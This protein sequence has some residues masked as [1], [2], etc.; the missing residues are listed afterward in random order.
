MDRRSA[1]IA[2]AGSVPL[3]RASDSARSTVLVELFTSEGCSSCPPADGVLAHLDHQPVSGVDIVVM[4]EHVDYWNHLG[5]VDAYSSPLYS[6]R[7]QRY[8]TRFKLESVYTPQMVIDG[9]TQVLGSDSYKITS[10][11]EQAALTPRA[12]VHIER[13]ETPSEEQADAARVYLSVQSVPASLR[14]ETFDVLLA[15]TE[16]GL[17]SYVTR[18]E[19]L[20]RTLKHTGVVRNLLSVTELNP[21]KSRGYTATLSI[22]IAKTWT[23]SKMRAVLF[24]Q[25]R[26]TQ[27]IAGVG[28][29]VL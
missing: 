10:A 28:S 24:L 12:A 16:S 15:L 23:R 19:N 29:C 17:A 4:A 11:I 18:G 22:G 6:A 9:R 3:L 13:S 2:L 1:L 25:S 21:R 7:Q 5:W 27:A 14:G 8:A 26:D 20:G